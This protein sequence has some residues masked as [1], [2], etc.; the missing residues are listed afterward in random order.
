MNITIVGG[1]EGIAYVPPGSPLF[2]VPAVL[3]S[4]YQSNV[5]VA[6]KNGARVGLMSALACTGE[7]GQWA[8]RHT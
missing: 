8:G 5:I 6:W 1:P 7:N 3:I 4:E 2:P